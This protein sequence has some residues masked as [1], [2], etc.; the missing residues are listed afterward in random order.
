VVLGIDINIQK[1]KWNS[2]YVH[3]KNNVH[4]TTIQGKSNYIKHYVLKHKAWI[5][6]LKSYAWE[7]WK[8]STTENKN[9]PWPITTVE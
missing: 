9:P 6:N 5:L 2:L 7:Q 1:K 3:L 8:F 4:K